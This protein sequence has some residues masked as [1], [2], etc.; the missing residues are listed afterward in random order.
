M[1]HV[2]ESGTPRHLRRAA[3]A[4]VCQV[5]G[6]RSAWRPIGMNEY[7]FPKVGNSLQTARRSNWDRRPAR[8]FAQKLFRDVLRASP[9]GGIADRTSASPACRS[10]TLSVPITSSG[11]S[12][13][14]FSSAAN[15]APS[16]RLAKALVVVTRRGCWSPLR[17]IAARAVAKA[18]RPSRTTGKSRAPASVNESGRGRRGT[19]PSRNSAPTAGSD[20]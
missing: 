4:I 3:R 1:L 10:R 16:H 14:A 12:G 17:L 2:L 5:G 6:S 15:V 9:A 8:R 20:G 11:A 18:S 13:R 7:M 19:E